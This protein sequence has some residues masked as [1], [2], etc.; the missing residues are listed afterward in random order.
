MGYQRWTAPDRL[1]QNRKDIPHIPIGDGSREINEDGDIWYK[2]W[3]EATCGYEP[4]SSFTRMWSGGKR[5]WFSVPALVA[6]T[7]LPPPPFKSKTIEFKDGDPWNWHVSNLYWVK[8]VQRK[9]SD[10][11]GPSPTT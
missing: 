6:T 10:Q 7:F 11:I 3:N 4:K 2:G 5:R 1:D 8:K 9:K